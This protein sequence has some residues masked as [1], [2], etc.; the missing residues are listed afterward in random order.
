MSRRRGPK[1]PEQ[2]PPPGIRIRYISVVCTG[3]GGHPEL[4]LATWQAWLW[5]DAWRILVDSGD[6]EFHGPMLRRKCRRCGRHVVL[7]EDTVQRVGAALAAESEVP[8]LDV[9]M[10]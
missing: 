5:G 2:E 10:L 7:Q 4:S 3:R 1:P 9:S 8:K 6:G